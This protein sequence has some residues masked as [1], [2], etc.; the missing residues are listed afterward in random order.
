MNTDYA[1]QATAALNQAQRQAGV[2]PEVAELVT[3]YA[4]L[5]YDRGTSPVFY[6]NISQPN[7][8]WED[9]FL[10]GW[11]ARKHPRMLERI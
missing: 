6:D 11:L 4:R 7:R 9:D 3:A 2:D 5:Q 1:W 10:C 8:K